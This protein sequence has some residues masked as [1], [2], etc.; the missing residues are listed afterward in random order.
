[1]SNARRSAYE[2]R[3][4]GRRTKRFGNLR[5]ASSNWLRGHPGNVSGRRELDW[6]ESDFLH[7][8]DIDNRDVVRV[9]YAYSLPD[10]KLLG[11]SAL[12]GK[13]AEWLTITPDNKTAYVANSQE[14][15]RDS[16][17]RARCPEA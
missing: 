17:V 2:L 16:A 12:S 7:G 8:S 9:L 1:V 10:L 5:C 4:K 6:D 15:R 11:S 3:A 13:G 14:V